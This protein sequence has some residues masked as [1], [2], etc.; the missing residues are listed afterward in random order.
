MSSRYWDLKIIKLSMLKW[1]KQALSLFL[2]IILPVPQII[3]MPVDS[4]RFL[5][6]GRFGEIPNVVFS[7]IV[8]P[9]FS[10]D[11]IYRNKLNEL[12]KFENYV[13]LLKVK[14]NFLL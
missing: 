7:T 3:L 2:T 5:K 4:D 9:P 13:N 14:T 6:Y 12:Q 10:L 1:Q 11:Y 8:C